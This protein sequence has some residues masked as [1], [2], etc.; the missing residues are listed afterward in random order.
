MIIYKAT[1][2]INGKIYIGKYYQDNLYRR[3]K[4]HINSSKKPQYYIH[5]AM[6]F[7][8][9]DNFKWEIIDYA[10]NQ[11]DLKI[12]EIKYIKEF[13]SFGAGGYNMTKG[14]DGIHGFKHSPKTK[15]RLSLVNQ[16]RKVFNRKKPESFSKEHREKLSQTS[17]GR[18]R[19][20]E[21]R[22]KNGLANKGRHHPPHTEERKRKMSESQKKRWMLIKEES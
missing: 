7:Y 22:L 8:G 20:L 13:N 2:L 5:R 18:P 9:I 19:S 16:G 11:D 17:K 4:S 21:T 14:G 15:E 3:M 12:L 6:S 10:N 1:N